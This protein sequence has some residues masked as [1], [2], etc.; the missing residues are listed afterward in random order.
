M[1]DHLGVFGG[2]ALGFRGGQVDD[3]DRHA[4]LVEE[5]DDIAVIGAPGRRFAA[6]RGD[7]PAWGFRQCRR[8]Q[9]L[10]QTHLAVG[11]HLNPALALLAEEL[12][13]EPVELLFEGDDF[14]AQSLVKVEDLLRSQA[15]RVFET[16]NAQDRR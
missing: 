7:Q 12:A 13:L 4:G 10:A 6:M 5:G 2:E 8:G 11:S 9:P 14:A 1:A 16:Q 15:R 3:F